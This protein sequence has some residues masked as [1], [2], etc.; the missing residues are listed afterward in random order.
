VQNSTGMNTNEEISDWLNKQYE[1]VAE[2]AYRRLTKGNLDAGDIGDLVALVKK[3]EP[4]KKTPRTFPAIGGNAVASVQLRLESMGPVSGIDA[5][6]PKKP[7]SFGDENISVVYGAN[8]SGKSGYAR[9]LSKA[10][11]KP[12]CSDLRSNV[13]AGPPSVQECTFTYLVG[14]EKKQSVWG[15]N[16]DPID[17]LK[18]VDVFDTECGRLYLEKDTELAYEPP[19]LSLFTDLVEACKLVEGAL[20]AEQAKL[21]SKLT[22]IAPRFASTE[23]GKAYTAL[24]SGSLTS[25]ISN[26][27][28]W[29]TTDENVLQEQRERVKIADPAGAA[30]KKREAKLQIEGIRAALD[31]GLKALGEKAFDAIWR[32]K[33]DA[34]TKRKSALEAARALGST[35]RLEG[36]GSATW[37]AMWEAASAY[38]KAEAYI[39]REFPHTNDGARCVLC[40]QDLD[41]AAQHRLR[42]FEEFV[43]GTL[44]KDACVAEKTLKDS[45]ATL[46]T[47]PSA[48]NV[49]MVCQVA[50]L[51][52]SVHA[53]L[54]AAWAKLEPLLASL[55]EGKLGD[56]PSSV[57]P[58]VPKL[59]IELDEH[60]AAA[61][62][63]AVEFDADAKSP[64]R[65]QA[66]ARVSE[67]EAKKW[68]AEFATPIQTEIDRLKKWAE[69]EDW[70]KRTS[71]KGISRKAGEL[72]QSLITEAYVQRFNDE[73]KQL[74]AHKVQV[75]LVKTGTSLAKSKH[76]IRL[77]DATEKKVRVADVLSEGER[78]IVALAAF[79]ADG[80][81][82]NTT[83]P[84]VFDDPISSLDQ[85]FEEK[86]IA[87]LIELSKNR[88]VLVFTHRLSFLGI[89]NDQ[90]DGALHDV[91]ISRES[92]GTGEPGG[93]PI[94]A[95]NPDGA[96]KNLK[97]ERL[98]RASKML[99]EE[100]SEIY[101]PLAKAICS[102]FR[103][104]LERIVEKLLLAGIIQRHSREVHTKHIRDLLKVGHEDCQ[105]IEEMMTKY[106]TFEHSQSSETSV[107]P[108]EPAELETDIDR[109]L[110]WFDEFKKRK[111]PVH[112]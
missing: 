41:E 20:S 72:S 70:K 55:R 45:L 79:I 54:E 62:K 47:R 105:L 25:K 59:L 27:L 42:G 106:S 66:L 103:I 7:L 43:K 95:R 33:E 6:N 40:H 38:S 52:E 90:T 67:L 108:P 91:H 44:E 94:F 4:Q 14:D 96:L 10:C 9:I 109:V 26:F 74:G 81:G 35:A 111:P 3:P 92:W 11:G 5:L 77:R 61:E 101:Y 15:A 21:V 31:R 112:N 22:A 68:V 107:E 86:V 100:G 75:E 84:F 87:R 18:A 89:M 12:H 48:D 64:D 76:G 102:D 104:I 65:A 85:I 39:G 16:T 30:K 36:L 2:A 60:A 58:E 29:T 71:T 69:F 98:A 49:T 99:K 53:S 97:N 73:L 17:D 51:P 28:T 83:A 82:R 80:A 78:R 63:A 13:Y 57:D 24:H 46:P 88:Q 56:G 93:V 50:G 110:S 23:A 37:K 32:M 19:E 1:W 34:T 8:G